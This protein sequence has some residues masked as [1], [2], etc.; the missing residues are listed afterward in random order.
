ML[1]NITEKDMQAK[2]RRR[3]CDAL[4]SYISSYSVYQR[5]SFIIIFLVV[6]IFVVAGVRR[7]IFIID[8]FLRIHP[9]E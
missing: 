5:E 3:K 4:P 2:K 9:V 6:V 8:V 7:F 1:Y